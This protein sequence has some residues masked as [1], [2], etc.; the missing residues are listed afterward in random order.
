MVRPLGATR[1]WLSLVLASAAS[2][3]CQA[4]PEAAPSPARPDLLLVTVDTLRADHLPTYGYHRDTAPQLAAWAAGATVFTNA[5]STSSWTVPATASLVTGV[6]PPSHGVVHGLI[7]DHGRVTQ[8]S[9]PTALPTLA[10][11]LTRAGYRTFAV[12]A[13]GHLSEAHGFA[14]GFARYDCV[15]FHVPAEN[16][17]RR[18]EQWR[19]EI[20]SSPAPVFVW[21]HYFDP[22][23]D[24]LRREPWFRRYRPDASATDL[25]AIRA[26]KLS[27]P[28]LPPEMLAAP[29]RVL[30]TAVGLY[31]SEIGYWDEYFHRLLA[32]FPRLA[33]A[34]R[35][36]TAD[37]G[38]EFM[39][40]GEV[41]HG[42]NLHRETMGIP[43]VVAGPGF[44]RA[45]RCD[46]LVSLLD[47]PVTLLAWAGAAAPPGWQGRPLQEAV[48]S[49]P[50]ERV[51][52]GFL[53]EVVANQ[54]SRAVL[55]KLIRDAVSGE[56]RL[57]DLAADPRETR[58][59]AAQEPTEVARLTT[60]LAE[61]TAALPPP[62]S[63]PGEVLVSAEEQERLH[64]LG[65]LSGGVGK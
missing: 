10:E 34:A 14:R 27:W 53:D 24:Y 58:D 50:G 57:Y 46:A 31:D 6:A 7:A 36:V 63:P 49:S 21:I 23:Y 54:Q 2:A 25:A 11:E 26:I 33:R 43:L 18:L 56:S 59:L 38:E 62:P 22:H 4:A 19:A 30:G 44:E 41:H 20:D 51:V 40:H 9:L 45:G 47:V 39:D 28:L 60:L 16:V 13:N 48:A 15:G 8:K 32:G 37:H 65:Y 61:V 42:N 5:H 3:A 52:T 64:A 55:W 12:T 35:V 17:N 1:W 29:E